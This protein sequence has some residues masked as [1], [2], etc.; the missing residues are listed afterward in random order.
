MGWIDRYMDGF[1]KSWRSDSSLS[2]GVSSSDHLSVRYIDACIR[3]DSIKV[4]FSEGRF[5]LGGLGG[6]LEA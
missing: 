5:F 1:V 2:I 4:R 6:G 3:E